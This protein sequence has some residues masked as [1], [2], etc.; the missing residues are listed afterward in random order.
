MP[1]PLVPLARLTPQAPTWLDKEN[2]EWRGN[3]LVRYWEPEWQSIIFGTPNSLLDK[4]ID[5]GFDGVY[6]DK[7]D[8]FEDW[9]KTRTGAKREMA[10]FVIKLAAYA[11]TKKPGFVIVP[12]NGEELLELSDYVRTIDAIAKEDLIFGGAARK[13]GER[14]PAKEILKAKAHLDKARKAR[15][16]VLAV[17]YLDRLDLVIEAKTK[18]TRYGY[19]PFFAERALERSPQTLT[20]AAAPYPPRNKSDSRTHLR[21]FGRRSGAFQ[22]AAF[23]LRGALAW[24]GPT[25][26]VLG[27]ACL[28]SRGA[29]ADVAFLCAY[30]ISQRACECGFAVYHRIRSDHR[31]RRDPDCE[32]RPRVAVYAGRVPGGDDHA[33]DCWMCRRS[34]PMFLLGLVVAAVLTGLIGVAMEV[35]LLR[36]IYRAPELLQLLATFGVVLI[37]QDLVMRVW[38]PLEILGPRAPGSAGRG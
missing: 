10:D 18:L 7:I 20:P 5:A 33:A 3:Y 13:D 14:N 9:E 28:N 27:A 22:L 36:R 8:S 30:P 15:K 26:G 4:I 2:P 16:P 25:G 23:Q 1:D 11:R 17:E 24:S 31:I 29:G 12:Q 32:F 37:V 6:L 19:I 34:F 35:V 38:G 21:L